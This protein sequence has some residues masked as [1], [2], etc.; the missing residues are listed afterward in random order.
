MSPRYGNEVLSIF[1]AWEDDREFLA[2]I[3][4]ARIA[5]EKEYRWLFNQSLMG[6]A[7]DWDHMITCAKALQQARGKRPGNIEGNDLLTYVRHII[8]SSFDA[9][10]T[11]NPWFE[12]DRLISLVK[13]QHTDVRI[14]PPYYLT[15]VS[16]SHAHARPSQPPPEKKRRSGATSHYWH[17]EHSSPAQDVSN[18]SNTRTQPRIIHTNFFDGVPF[19]R[20]VL[21]QKTV[22]RHLGPR[23]ELDGSEL[24][25]ASELLLDHNLLQTCT[26]GLGCKDFNKSEVD[27]GAVRSTESPY[28]T[29]PTSAKKRPSKKKPP[30]GTVSCIPFPPLSSP[31]FGIVQE[32]L[33]HEPFWLLIAVTFLI[34]TNGQHALPIFYKVKQRFPTPAHLADPGNESELL[35]MIHHLGLS[36]HR[37]S[38]IKKYARLFLEAPPKAGVRYRVKNYDR[39]DM[40]P[41]P[42]DLGSDSEGSVA[43]EGLLGNERLDPETWEIGHM[44]KGKYAIDSWRIFCRDKLL[45]RA[46]DWNGKG[47]EP[48]FQPEWMRARPQDKELR[49]CLRWMWMRE[50]W[51][52]DPVTGELT[53]L[54]EELQRAV[55]EGRVEYD[56]TGALRIL[57]EKRVGEVLNSETGSA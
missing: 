40:S 37:V 31:L 52:W 35:A 2:D 20:V 24:P 14:E 11:P 26:S 13:S 50:G 27:T 6:V 53:V 21:P 54:R 12:T 49:A 42:R 33:S 46:E 38:I 23:F 22:A 34:K 8:N 17:D 45:G 39:R 48:E 19:R 30:P 36:S 28:F 25:L 55:N 44:T 16:N 5:P 1:E 43:D 9:L 32:K 15:H 7:E 29:P 47:R 3:F 57:K 51:E 4:E 56:D 10:P 18:L 41:P